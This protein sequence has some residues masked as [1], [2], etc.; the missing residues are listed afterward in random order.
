MALTNLNR[1]LLFVAALVAALAGGFNHSASQAQTPAGPAV[2]TVTGKIGRS[3][4]PGFEATRDVFFNYHQRSF[5]QAFEF[6]LLMLEALGM[7]E[8]VISYPG[9]TQPIAVEGPLLRDVLAAAGAEPGTI[10]ITALDGFTT[11]IDHAALERENWIVALKAGG[12][13]LSL[14]QQGPAWVVYARLDGKPGT[15][16]DEERWPW[17]AFLFEVE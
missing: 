9:L 15:A 17:A 1:K 14:G 12:R 8:A 2:L 10:R 13:Y 5:T 6:D 16:Q 11:I 4:R 3:N 7:R